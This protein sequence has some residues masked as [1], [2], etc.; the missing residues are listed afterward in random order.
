MPTNRPTL[1]R[2]DDWM[3]DQER[4][5]GSLERRANVRNAKQLLGPGFGPKATPVVDWNTSSL[6]F[7]G[8]FYCDVG[9]LNSPDPLVGWIGYSV[10]DP[11]GNGWL[12]LVS[13]SPTGRE[14]RRRVTTALGGATVF[15]TWEVSS[16]TWT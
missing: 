7:N 1:D 13:Q 11:T 16:T 12:Y 4:R 14:F 6:V 3:R 10:I 2:F 8:F 15:G 5:T 9:S